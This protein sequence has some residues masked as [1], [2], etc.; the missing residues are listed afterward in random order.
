[1]R[2]G[3]GHL[4]Y[5]SVAQPALVMKAFIEVRSAGEAM[6]RNAGL[7]ATIL[8]PWYILG[9]GHWWPIALMPVYK[10]AEMIPSSRGSA[11][12]LGLVT[13]GQMVNA[14]VNAVESPPSW[15]SVRVVE[16]PE[17]RGST[18]GYGIKDERFLKDKG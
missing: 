18:K 13:I 11:Q 4:V 17:I 8:R 15:G 16:V 10:I 14:L 3:A 12:R 7:T 1:M 5:V 9:P 2:V 6:I